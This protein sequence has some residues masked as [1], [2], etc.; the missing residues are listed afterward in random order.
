MADPMIEAQTHSLR[1]TCACIALQGWQS[2]LCVRLGPVPGQRKNR[3]AY[4]R[5]RKRVGALPKP[6]LAKTA[7]VKNDCR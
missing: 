2:P 6:G 4:Y 5:W 1:G 7:C 3:R